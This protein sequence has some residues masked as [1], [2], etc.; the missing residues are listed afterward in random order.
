MP[1]PESPES[2]LELHCEGM[3]TKKIPGKEFRVGC[4][5]IAIAKDG[6]RK[7]P[8][9][10][11][12]GTER[13]IRFACS[14]CRHVSALTKR[15][16][17]KQNW[18]RA[19]LGLDAPYHHCVPGGMLGFQAAETVCTMVT[20]YTWCDGSCMV[21]ST[22]SGGWWLLYDMDASAGRVKPR[23]CLQSGRR[24]G[25]IRMPGAFNSSAAAHPSHNP[26]EFS[27]ACWTGIRGHSGELC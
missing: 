11:G 19:A 2:C 17:R 8:E 22:V 15:S 12:A 5:P 16:P 20:Y 1:D 4:F 14:S 24:A 10:C 9:E 26:V 27:T 21:P 3:A 18:F 13:P 6:H 7:I 23:K 25:G